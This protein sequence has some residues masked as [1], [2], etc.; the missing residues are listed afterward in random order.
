MTEYMTMEES[1]ERERVIEVFMASV[2]LAEIKKEDRVVLAL[3]A[4]IEVA[5]E[6]HRLGEIEDS[7]ERIQSRD[8]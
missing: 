7:Y 6:L 5:D 4:A 8:E 2:A 3:A 1:V